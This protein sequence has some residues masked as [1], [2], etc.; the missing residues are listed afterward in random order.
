MGLNT[1]TKSSL[2]TGPFLLLYFTHLQNFFLFLS[3]S[4]YP[5]FYFTRFKGRNNLTFLT[6]LIISKNGVQTPD[7][8]PFPVR[9]NLPTTGARLKMKRWV[10]QR[11]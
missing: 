3:A 7:V 6:G 1:N 9:R 2:L 8:M 11:T 4:F 5:P 10:L